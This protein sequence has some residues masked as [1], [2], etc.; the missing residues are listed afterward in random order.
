MTFLNCK[1]C[2]NSY[3]L[4]LH[5]SM[6]AFSGKHMLSV[7]LLQL[8]EKIEILISLQNRSSAF[9]HISVKRHT[10]ASSRLK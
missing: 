3:F 2:A 4:G 7:K 6:T 8:Y 1:G 10:S 5:M 9:Q